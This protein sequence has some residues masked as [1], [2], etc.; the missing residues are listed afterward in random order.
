MAYL[1]GEFYFWLLAAALFG[2]VLG[3]LTQVGG[4]WTS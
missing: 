1:F 3:L 4:R 2:L